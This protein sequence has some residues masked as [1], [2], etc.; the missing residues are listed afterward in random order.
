[1]DLEK[2]LGLG[3]DPSTEKLIEFVNIKLKAKGLPIFGREEDYPVLQMSGPMLDN[4]REKNRLLRDYLP[5][6]DQRVQKFIDRYLGELEVEIPRLPGESLILE[7]HGIARVLSVPPDRD[8]FISD[9]VESYRVKQGVLHNPKNDRR[10]TKGSFHIVEGGMTIPADKIAV[11]KEVF[12]RML[13]AALNPPSD[14]ARLPFTS[15]QKAQA[16]AMVSLLMRPVVVP[17]VPGYLS[18]RSM[19]VRFFA[20][21]SLVSNLDFVESIF[22]NAGDPYLPE[23]DAALDVDGWTG[24]SGCVILAPQ[25]LLLRKKELGLPHISAATERQKRDGMCWESEDEFYNDGHAFKVTARDHTGVVV[26]LI[27]DNY[28]GYCKKEVKTQISYSANL[29]GMSEEEH[30]GGALA[31]PGYD[32]GED[33]YSK[34]IPITHT[35]TFADTLK[36]MGDRIE[37]KAEGYA[38]D[39]R[40]P[41]IVYLPEDVHFNMP[42]Q[43]I[44]WTNE[45][46]EDVVLKM[47]A[48][49]SYLLPSGYKLGMHLP[50]VGRRWRLVG[51]VAEGTFCHK[52]CTVSGGGKSEISKS[53]AD[54]ILHGPI[55]VNNFKEDF[56]LVEQIINRDY[57][58][59]YREEAKEKRS[60]G[61]RPILSPKRSLGSV[62]KLLTPNPEY[63][64]EYNEWL[65]SIPFYI[66]DLVF[67]VKRYWKPDWGESWR[68]R[69]SVDIIDG[70]TGHELKHRNNY[71]R[72]HYLRIGFTEE[73]NWRTFGLRK[74]FNPAVKVQRED[75]ISASVVVPADK[76]KDLNPRDKKPSYKFVTNCEWRLFQRPDEAIHRGYDKTTESD[77]SKNNVFFSNY[78]PMTH[79]NATG[80]VDNAIQFSKYSEPMQGV[81][82]G[83]LED[84]A[85]TY[86]V[87]SAHPRLV[88]GKP[89]KN[90][91][92]L[93]VR[94]DITN[95][96]DTYLA[97]IGARL[98]R[99]VTVSDALPVPVS[100]V[101]AGRRNNPPDHDAGVKALCPYNPLHYQELPELFM[102]FI[103][104]LTGKSPS[105]TG[106]G[107]EGA[108]TKGPF[109]NLPAII[110]LNNAL[111]SYLCSD[112][113]CFTSAAGYVG[114]KYRVD[115]DVSL[116]IPEIW[117]RMQHEE[118]DPKWLIEHKYLEKVED[119]DYEGRCILASR[120]G[121][122]INRKF[123]RVF[124][125]RIFSNP[126]AV[127]NAEMLKPE[128]Q[129]MDIFVEAI[130]AIVQTQK[131]VAKLYFEDGT[132][133][134]ACPPLKALLSIMAEGSYEGKGIDDPEIRKL[135][136]R[137]AML[138]SPW[139][140]ERLQVRQSVICRQLERSIR[141]LEHFQTLEQFRE[142]IEQMNIRGRLQHA[143]EDLAYRTNPDYINSLVGTIGTDPAVLGAKKA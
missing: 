89:S 74:D 118:R 43:K 4:L 53:I 73:G 91:R 130:D 129:D 105:T 110:D 137:E 64:D 5:P 22:G 47:L 30:A 23:N 76:V 77:F 75:D 35:N 57:S 108:L 121:Y 109:N 134:L 125:G 124:L 8:E 100:S 79:A 7:R 42:E 44:S 11:P 115:H 140:R 95:P 55:F 10:T 45:K 113:A 99:K 98:H 39:K 97:E 27:A 52:P 111:V 65:G 112:E 54:A 83:F 78:Q 21:G 104:S 36:T 120:L 84:E 127:F 25:M 80:L 46:G 90:P 51:T 142:E 116:L 87:S 107:S 81:V 26:T 28:F 128:E 49:Y 103:A 106:A 122:R 13:K 119:F 31:F 139:Y 6:C 56:D 132:I 60:K 29:Y 136:T 88:D 63:R 59:R 82:K 135:F 40:Y 9:I 86:F 3:S 61:Y 143:R 96:R 66:K 20:P 50:G 15:S 58:D 71:I 138:E 70:T 37:L 133:E 17:E 2:Q 102:D 117:S 32:L 126:M 72:S 1:M 33:I 141:Y 93:Q 123:T 12:A 14:L 85:H 92:Y 16:E 41:D 38:V 48:G 34:D 94:P 101:L 24:H 131:N 18:E 68:E 62:I 69:F 67:M 114:P 19:E